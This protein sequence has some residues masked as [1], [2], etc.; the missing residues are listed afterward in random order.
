MA[1]SKSKKVRRYHVKWVNTQT[2]ES[3]IGVGY[4]TRKRAQE[5]ADELNATTDVIKHTVVTRSL[6]AEADEW[7]EVDRK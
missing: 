6:S 2:G 1:G 5:I 7:V 3:F 4:K